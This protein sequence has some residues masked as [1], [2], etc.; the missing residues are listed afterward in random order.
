MTRMDT[1]PA[2]PKRQPIASKILGARIRAFRVKYGIN[3]KALGAVLGTSL[4]NLSN[5]ENGYNCLSV[6]MMAALQ[7]FASSYG[8]ESILDGI[9]TIQCDRCSRTRQVI[10]EDF[11]LPGFVR[12]CNVCLVQA[13]NVKARTRRAALSFEAVEVV[14]GCKIRQSWLKSECCIDCT[15]TRPG[16]YYRCLNY[17]CEQQ[18]YAWRVDGDCAVSEASNYRRDIPG[19]DCLEAVR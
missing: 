5:I 18:W 14:P 7:D 19:A 11:E 12:T 3:T 13:R 6:P 15:V 8:E 1:V 17:A 2:R 10:K 9:L 16:D 4:S